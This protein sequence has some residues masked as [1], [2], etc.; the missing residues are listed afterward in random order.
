MS[1]ACREISAASRE[2]SSH[3][4][5]IH[6]NLPAFTFI[7]TW[8]D[9]NWKP[10]QNQATELSTKISRYSRTTFT[11]KIVIWIANYQD[12]LSPSGKHFLTVIML[13]L[14]WLKFS[15]QLSHTYNKLCLN[16][17]FVRKWICSLL[18]L[19][20]EIFPS[21]SCQCRLLSKKT[22]IIRIF[23]I[24]GWHAVPVNPNKWSSTVL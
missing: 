6:R 17:L 4:A 15:L 3:R 13:H 14:S 10:T 16:V 1:T 20:V 22:P 8:I 21:S 18:Q 9:S 24:S 7:S 23:C 2:Q 19:F 5:K 11:R 12:R